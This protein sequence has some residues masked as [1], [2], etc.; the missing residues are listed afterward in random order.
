MY[1]WAAQAT[2]GTAKRRRSQ[3]GPVPPSLTRTRSRRHML[4][5]CRWIIETLL[6]Y[7][8]FFTQLLS[9]ISNLYIIHRSIERMRKLSE[10]QNWKYVQT[11]CLRHVFPWLCN[12]LG[13]LPTKTVLSLVFSL[14]FS[15]VFSLVFWVVS[16][17]PH[18]LLILFWQLFRAPGGWWPCDHY[19]SGP[20]ATSNLHD[21]I[22]F[23][24]CLHQHQWGWPVWCKE[25]DCP[26]VV[27]FL[28]AGS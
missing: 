18:H 11:L 24:N 9:S 14:V 1:H 13:C 25:Q 17:C 4:L 26:W 19:I 7:V 15:T 20:L 8:E 6:C 27:G 10:T 2:H 16:D 12:F 23:N 3:R 5:F 28:S 21:Y 22:P